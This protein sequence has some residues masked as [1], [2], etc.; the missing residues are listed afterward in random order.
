MQVQFNHIYCHTD[1]KY[2]ENLASLEGSTINVIGLLFPIGA[3]FEAMGIFKALGDFLFGKD[4]KIFDEKGKVRH[5]LPEKKWQAWDQ[6]IRAN[7]DYNWHEH[8]GEKRGAA[9]TGKSTASSSS[10]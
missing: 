4:P 3:R 8:T 1:C 9:P 6:R 7:P 5:Q 2:A 10:G